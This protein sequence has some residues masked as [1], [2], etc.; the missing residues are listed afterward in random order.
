MKDQF[1][2]G[3]T[4]D[5]IRL[6]SAWE[7]AMRRL[8]P[9]V[10]PAWF[11]RFLHVLQPLSLEN[12]QAKVAAPGKFVFEWVQKRFA[13]TL[14]QYLCDELGQKVS[15]VLICEARDRASTPEGDTSVRLDAKISEDEQGFTPNPKFTFDSFVVGQS[16]RLAVAGAKAVSQEPGAKYNP[17]FIYGS[18][19]LGKTHLLHA[20]ARAT[21]QNHPGLSLRYMSAQQFAEMFVAA[22]QSNRVELFRRKQRS[23]Q[24]WLIDD[25]QLVMGREKTQEEIFHTYNYLHG[26]GMQI[27]LC[28]DRPP[29][30]LYGMDERLR[31]RFEAGLVADIQLPDTET[32]CAILARKAVEEGVELPGLVA[33]Y[34]AET[35]PGNI[36]TLEGAL[37]RLVAYTSVE[38]LPLDM[39][40]AQSM[41]ERFYHGGILQ[42]PSFD[43]V[44]SAVGRHFR[45][46]T[47]EIKGTSRKAPITE[48]RH[49]AVYILRE[50]TK[51][52][53]KHLGSLFGNRDHT[54]MMHA[55]QRISERMAD[56][57]DFCTAVRSLI[58]D[59]YPNA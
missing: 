34:L 41:V 58:R 24:V 47:D 44:V 36:R 25:I 11:E 7:Q 23:A 57:Q 37:T 5:Q 49:T 40:S 26:L 52:S 42:K 33:D 1:T 51:D 28:A 13:D 30:D 46:P 29:R 8:G 20:I 31:S 19:G 35:V 10:P 17:L 6:R 18:S 43:Q 53:W 38:G 16:N 3:E 39:G 12:G 45:I 59:V 14:E 27:V 56:D 9:E 55:Y 21:Q 50:T 2:L 48:A 32:R 4:D 22:L 54:S 15:L